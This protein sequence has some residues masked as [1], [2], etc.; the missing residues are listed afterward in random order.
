[1][2]SLFSDNDDND[3]VAED[4]ADTFI[5]L[6]LGMLDHAERETYGCL[7]VDCVCFNLF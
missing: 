1:M 4:V 2:Y 3:D 6:S 7:V 5:P